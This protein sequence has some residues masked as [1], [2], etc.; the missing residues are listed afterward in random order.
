MN[1]DFWDTDS[2]IR[3]N[4]ESTFLFEINLN[5]EFLETASMNQY[6]FFGN[7]QG[8]L[9][10]RHKNIMPDSN[11]ITIEELYRGS[12]K[13]AKSI[14]D[15]N[16]ILD[17]KKVIYP[18]TPPE[19]NKYHNLFADRNGHALILESANG[20]N[21][22]TTG[23]SDF[24]IMTNFPVGQ[25]RG[26]SY[27]NVQGAG[28]DRYIKAYDYLLQHSDFNIEN[29][30][31]ILKNTAQ[32]E[33]AWETLISMVFIPDEMTVYFALKRDFSKIFKTDMFQ[34]TLE[35]YKGFGK[36]IKMD[37]SNSGIPLNRLKDL[38][39]EADKGH[40]GEKSLGTEKTDR[41]DQLMT[42]DKA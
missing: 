1:F 7:F 28:S 24:M 25:Y 33:D 26:M 13:S 5:G 21:D 22:I 19:Y 20:A 23:C 36:Y 27:K 4:D 16:R 12:M 42:E 31:E 32:K 2:R 17:G 3:V 35:T 30:F 40:L 10:D 15:F 29:A 38:I 41:I 11:S 6:G 37:A 34:K 39:L 14:D 9:S 8:N 18:P